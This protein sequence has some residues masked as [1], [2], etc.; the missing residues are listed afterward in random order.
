MIIKATALSKEK[1]ANDVAIFEELK[2]KELLPVNKIDY[3]S[4]R[5]EIKCLFCYFTFQAYVHTSNKL[6]MVVKGY[7]ANGYH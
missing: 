5:H 3:D 6:C 2:H 1:L 4:V 7:S